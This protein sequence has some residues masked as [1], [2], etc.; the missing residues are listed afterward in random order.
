MEKFSGE[1]AE[2]R[3]AFRETAVTEE[4]ALAAEVVP[5]EIDHEQQDS[6]KQ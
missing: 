6:T 5:G 4:E 3:G 1:E 2:K